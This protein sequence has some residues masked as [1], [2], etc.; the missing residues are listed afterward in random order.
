MQREDGKEKG[1][2]HKLL[3]GHINRNRK[4]DALEK[5]TGRYI[6][7]AK[8]RWERKRDKTQII[9]RAH[10]LEQKTEALKKKQ[11]VAERTSELVI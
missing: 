1:T 6:N 8:G 2:K 7:S 10:K 11:D 9:N 5:E 3:T 4:T